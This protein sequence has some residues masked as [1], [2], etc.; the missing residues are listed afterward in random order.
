[1]SSEAR[2]W[3]TQEP[4]IMADELREARILRR[5]GRVW[6]M[7]LM[8][9][10]IAEEAGPRAA[11]AWIGATRWARGRGAD[12]AAA[13]GAGRPTKRANRQGGPTNSAGQPTGRANHQG[14]P[15][16]RAGQPTGRANRQGGPTTRRA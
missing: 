16:N 10:P 1:M 13:G 6:L 7:L 15:T 12:E 14:G 5:M 2:P 11:E 8:R 9:S 4:S 3:V